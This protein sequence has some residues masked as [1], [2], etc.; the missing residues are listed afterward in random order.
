MLPRVSNSSGRGVRHRCGPAGRASVP[1]CRHC[2]RPAGGAVRSGL[3]Y[4]RT[5]RKTPTARAALLLMN[6][7]GNAGAKAAAA[8]LT[9][10]GMSSLNGET[11]VR[12]RG[13]R[14]SSAALGHPVAARRDARFSTESRDAN[15]VRAR[16]RTPAACTSCLRSRVCGAPHW[17]MYARGCRRRSRRAAR[18]RE[19]IIRAAHRSPSPIR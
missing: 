14:V 5:M 12:A 10:I 9:T 13:Q 2:G 7:G 3:L 18:R 4:A 15:T 1:I 16:C 17:D 6:A 8:L 11:T 19:H